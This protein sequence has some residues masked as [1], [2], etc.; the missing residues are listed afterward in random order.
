MPRIRFIA[1][2]GKEYPVE[3]ETGVSLMR[4]AIEH[5]VPGIVADCGGALTCATCHVHVD[6]DWL[7][8]LVPPVAGEEAMLECALDPDANSRL[9]CQI[10][11]T[12]ALD[13]LVV[14][15]PRAQF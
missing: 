14:N 1:A 12:D 6:P 4:A 5:D 3:A 15:V 11:V 7:D 9:S 10:A 2:N 13:G 8:R